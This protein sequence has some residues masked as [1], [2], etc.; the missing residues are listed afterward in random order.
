MEECI[1]TR[2]AQKWV[3]KYLFCYRDTIYKEECARPKNGRKHVHF[4][5]WKMEG[6]VS[7]YISGKWMEMC[8][9]PFPEKQMEMCPFLFPKYRKDCV[10]SCFRNIGRN[11]SVTISGKTER[12]VPVPVSEIS[13]GNMSI[14]G[15]GKWKEL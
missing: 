3:R 13:E 7:V 6:I 1:R 5:F 4:H 8:L 11:V 14:S 2:G 10:R 15:S 12:I 9:F